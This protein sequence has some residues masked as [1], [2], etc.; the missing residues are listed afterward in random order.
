MAGGRRL[1]AAAVRTTAPPWC[2]GLVWTAL[3]TV[4]V[5]PLPGVN[6]KR[7]SGSAIV[8]V[9]R[10][11]PFVVCRAPRIS[12]GHTLQSSTN[13]ATYVAEVTVVFR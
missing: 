10:R 13:Q 9:G 1:A 7:W 4:P 6:A 2:G 12:I 8:S 5:A 3:D 11:A